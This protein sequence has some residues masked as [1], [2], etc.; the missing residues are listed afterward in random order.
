M[1]IMY[2]NTTGK[3]EH[4]KGEKLAGPVITKENEI[5]HF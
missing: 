2:E 3:K 1:R 5:P 4:C